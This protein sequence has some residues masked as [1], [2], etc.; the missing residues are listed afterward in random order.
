MKKILFI[1]LFCFSIT[2]AQKNTIT[3]GNSYSDYVKIVDVYQSA[4]LNE[5][6]V[7]LEFYPTVS[8]NGTLHAP[9]G[10]SPYV[11]TDKKGN[12]YALKTQSGWNGLSANGFGSKTLNAYEK[13]TVR[14]YFHKVPDIKDIYSLTEVDC[15]GT[16]CWNFYDIKVT[17]NR[18]NTVSTSY[19]SNVNDQ[20][21][22]D[23]SYMSKAKNTNSTTTITTKTT[24]EPSASFEK[25]W[26]DYDVYDEK[27][28]IGM[29]IHNR[30]TV[31]NLKGGTCYATIRV[32]NDSEFLKTDEYG[33][34]NVSG[35]LEIKSYLYPNS[36]YRTYS[37]RMIFLPYN[38]LRSQ[39]G[40]GA[41]TLKLD[42]DVWNMDGSLLKHF[43]FKEFKYTAY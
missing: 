1:S 13:T 29:R 10:T 23:G 17:M 41:H 9:S 20:A 6:V 30:F 19:T 11:L 34:K 36:N 42:L 31:K 8:Q 7:K 4:I 21:S 27:G 28:N 39:L 14:L 15:S 26:V 18:T 24:P 35:Q 33:V 32:M 37:D 16:N 43:G 25:I 2:F 38:Y 5:T 3:V 40:K 22:S 12:R